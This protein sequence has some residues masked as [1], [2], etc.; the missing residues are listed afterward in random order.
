MY[1]KADISISQGSVVTHVSG[2][3]IFN[4]CFIANLLLSVQLKNSENQ[5]RGDKNI[6]TYFGSPCTHT[7][8]R[9]MM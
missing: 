1:S 4:D 6:V 5:Q 3:G 8:K 7:G 9:V 2:G